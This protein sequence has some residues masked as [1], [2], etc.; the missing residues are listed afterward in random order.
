MTDKTPN[1]ADTGEV[2]EIA[3]SNSDISLTSDG[4]G[5][6][7][8]IAPEVDESVI[9]AE[10]S[11][12][13]TSETSSEEDFAISHDPNEVPVDKK[14]AELV[15][16]ISGE[17]DRIHVTRDDDTLYNTRSIHHMR[18]VDGKYKAWEWRRPCFRNISVMVI[19]DSM[20]RCFKRANEKI[21]GYAII[22]YGGLDL[23]ELIMILKY[24]RLSRDIDL[25]SPEIRAKLMDGSLRISSN[26][27]CDLCNSDCTGT[28]IKSFQ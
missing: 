26:R 2:I 11:D 4:P 19:G 24:G 5:D 7:V 12:E 23:L 17:F 20:I 14:A 15:E 22:A 10:S 9:S 8:M 16:A 6:D 1:Q 28:D 18:K 3:E 27:S 21:S 25:Q 13:L